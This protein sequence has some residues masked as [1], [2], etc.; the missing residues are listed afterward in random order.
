MFVLEAFPNNTQTLKMAKWVFDIMEI[1]HLFFWTE[2][3]HFPKE[4]HLHS[5]IF[6]FCI[7]HTDVHYLDKYFNTP[8]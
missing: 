6:S 3:N 1:L 5:H 7:P 8:I 4:L 2:K